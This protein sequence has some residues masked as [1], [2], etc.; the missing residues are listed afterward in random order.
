M[1]KHILTLPSL[2]LSANISLRGKKK[3]KKFFLLF[4]SGLLIAAF[5]SLAVANSK[6]SEL[7]KYSTTVTLVISA[8]EDEIKNQVYSY[9]SRELRA[10]GDVQL[11]EDN[12]V[13]AVKSNTEWVIQIIAMQQENKDRRIIGWVMSSV[14]LKPILRDR[15]FKLFILNKALKGE[16]DEKLWQE[17]FEQLRTSCIV[18]GHGIRSGS[19]E[20]LQSN[21]K[22]I[23]AKFDSE[24]LKE[25][26][27]ADQ[28]L[29]K[30]FNKLREKLSA[31]E[32]DN[33]PKDD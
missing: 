26:R 24:C 5:I 28:Q 18:S 3:M 9:I 4:A 10:L 11:L 14:I 7:R 6:K 30:Q 13:W 19:P 23:V 8:T 1:L 20:D 21:C 33:E 29:W 2:L 32:K 25:S 22:G 17:L 12:S 15:D 27:K 31:E 16:Y